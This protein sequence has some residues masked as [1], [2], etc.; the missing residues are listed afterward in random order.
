MAF[1]QIDTVESIL[2]PAA[3]MAKRLTRLAERAEKEEKQHRDAAASH[4]RSADEYR[5]EAKH[6]R[7]E[8]R[9]V[10]ALGRVVR[11]KRKG[12]KRARAPKLS[13]HGGLAS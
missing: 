11:K 13:L 7:T 10:S 5:R 9:K 8:L 6:A 2:R 3:K 1:L 12:A 4:Q